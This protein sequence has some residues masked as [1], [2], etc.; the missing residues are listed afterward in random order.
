[1][2]VEVGDKVSIALVTLAVQE[3]GIGDI[4]AMQKSQ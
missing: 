2:I 3:M 4:V 1:V